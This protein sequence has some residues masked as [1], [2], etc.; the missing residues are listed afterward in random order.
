MTSV[1]ASVRDRKARPLSETDVER[2]I[3]IDRGHSGQSRRRFFEKRFA[4]AQAHPDDY[5]HIGLMWGG[6]MRG[7]ASARILRGEFGHEQSVAVLDAI[8]TEAQTQDH[9]IGAA[10]MTE[11][12]EAMRARGVRLLHSQALWSRHDLLHFLDASGFKLA[13]R[14][15]LE[16]SVS[17]PLDEES[18]EI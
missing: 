6:A 18:E 4:A 12:R 14:F 15:A 17:E 13:P 7:F 9:G 10:L 5:I 11:L 16:R 3:A 2:V 8:G 1:A